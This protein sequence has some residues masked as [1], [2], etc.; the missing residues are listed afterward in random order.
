MTSRTKLSAADLRAAMTTFAG[1]LRSHKDVINRLNVFPVP[2]GDTG[3]NMTLT[4]ESVVAAFAPL[5]DDAT[6]DEVCTAIARGSLMGARGNS[7]VILSQLLRGLVEKFRSVAS[8]TPALLAESLSHADVLARQAV[9]RPVEGTILSVAR[10]AA[11]GANAATASLSNLVRSARDRAREALAHTPDQLP[12]LRLAGVVDSGG[13]GLVLLFDALCHVVSNDPL[14]D[15]PT[16]DSIEVHASGAREALDVPSPRYEVMYLLDA[17]DAKMHAFRDVWSGIGDSIVIVGGDGLYNCHIH[18]DEIGA[19]VE[20]ALDAGRPREIRVTDL[21]GQVLEERWVRDA[22]VEAVESDEP[23]PPTSVV[24]VVAGDGVGRIFKSLGVRVLVPGGQSM[25]PSTADLVAAVEATGS[26]EVVLLPNN[27][28]IVPVANQV[29]SLVTQEVAVAPTNSIVE[30]FA[31]LLAYDPNA[32]AAHNATAMSE[33][34]RQVVAGEVTRAVR[35]TTTDAGPVKRGDWIGL[36]A[37]GVVSV[38]ESLGTACNGLLEAIITAQHELL[39]VIEGEGSDAV[40]T[41]QVTAFVAELFPSVGV[42]V[43]HGGQPLYPYLFGVE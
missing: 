39:T 14:P 7:G 32:T 29:N 18:T 23:A 28:N 36:N 31:A 5:D 35:D 27:S 22:A 30:G 3:T 33:A 8:I 19:A 1:L 10:A 13:S 43:H 41:R 20:A 4:V 2:D 24:A 12:V 6:M 38:A 42:E 16:L 34:A 40:T 17:D 15:P 25:N 26:T 9:V 37:D 21:A 11:Q